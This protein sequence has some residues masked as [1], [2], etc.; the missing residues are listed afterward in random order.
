MPLLLAV[1]TLQTIYG[2][3]HDQEICIKIRSQVRGAGRLPGHFNYS[4]LRI[5][6][7]VIK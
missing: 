7:N 4:K 2:W 6:T 1:A 3:L 5:F